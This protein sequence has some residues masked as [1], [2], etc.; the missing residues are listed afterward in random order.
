MGA[1]AS[2]KRVGPSPL[3]VPSGRDRPPGEALPQHAPLYPSPHCGPHSYPTRVHPPPPA[4]YPRVYTSTPGEAQGGAPLPGTAPTP[5]TTPYTPAALG[6]PAS[7][8]LPQPTS[9][10][11]L[12][13][14][15]TS[16]RAERP[17]PLPDPGCRAR[18][19]D[20]RCSFLFLRLFS[21]GWKNR[22]PQ[23]SWSRE[24]PGS[25]AG[26]TKDGGVEAR[27]PPP[28]AADSGGRG[29]HRHQGCGLI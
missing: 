22:C 15:V 18:L 28:P 11:V 25:S 7:L 6:S 10:Q 12:G 2:Q 9:P 16:V 21:E 24:G 17:P 8:A 19:I 23:K 5:Q 4:A 26:K 3:P 13:R 27:V 1:C 29:R 14:A 20:P